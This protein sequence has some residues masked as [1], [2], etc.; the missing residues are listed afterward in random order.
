[1]AALSKEQLIQ[2]INDCL[3][4]K[5]RTG[6]D[7]TFERFTTCENTFYSWSHHTALDELWAGLHQLDFRDSNIFPA[8]LNSP[9]SVNLNYLASFPSQNLQLQP[10]ATVRLSNPNE[11]LLGSPAYLQLICWKPGW[12]SQ[13]CIFIGGSFSSRVL[14]CKLKFTR[15]SLGAVVVIQSNQM[16]T[17]IEVC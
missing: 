1:M 13:P 16:P 15:H 11:W 17:L 5:V 8:L 14:V 2:T 10:L 3:G 12:K 9:L 7:M 6:T 4:F